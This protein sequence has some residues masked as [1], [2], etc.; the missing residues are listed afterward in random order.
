M[1]TNLI[2]CLNG[3]WAALIIVFVFKGSES[4][5]GVEQWQYTFG[6]TAFGVLGC[7]PQFGFNWL[8]SGHTWENDK[9]E[10][11]RALIAGVVSACIL[12]F[13]AVGNWMWI[14]AILVLLFNLALWKWGGKIFGK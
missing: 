13:V 8:Q 3:L 14:S 5:E 10:I 9:A 7:L 12:S 1:R 4:M 2:N 6:C 11:L